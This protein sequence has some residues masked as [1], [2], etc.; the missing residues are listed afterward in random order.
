[1][2]LIKSR[3][4][5]TFWAA[6][7]L[8]L[9][10][11][12]AYYGVFNLLA[13]YLTGSQ[14]TGALGFSQVE[15]G[16]IMGIV[17]AI[18]Y[19]LPVI[20]GSLADRFGYKRVLVTAFIVLSSGYYLMGLVS[21][22]AG[23]FLT[24]FYV[25]IGA[26]M[27]KPII[28]ATIARTTNESNSSVGFGIFYMIINIGGLIGPLVASELREI[29][30]NYIFVMSG[31]A[32]LVNLVIVLFFYRE[33]GRAADPEQAAVPGQ[34]P[35]S[36]SIRNA[37]RNI[38][39]A[40]KDTKFML[41][42]LIIIAGWTVYW[43]YFFSL[44]IYI[45]QWVDTGVVY[46]GI[47]TIFPRLADALATQD[48]VILAEKFITLDALFIVSFQVLLSSLVMRFKPINTMIAGF[49]VNAIGITLAL[50]TRNGWFLVLSILVFSAGEMAFSPKIL[51]YIGRLAPGDRAALYMGTYFMPIAAGNI[52]AGLLSGKIYE[53]TADKFIMLAKEVSKWG[54]QIP[55]ISETFSQNDYLAAAAHGMGMDVSQ[56]N[57]YLWINYNPALFGL[58]LM[59]IGVLTCLLLIVY[60]KFIFRYK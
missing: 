29:S 25:A 33:P 37:F 45:D 11:R 9:F 17:N 18:L 21:S 31:G 19:F 14:E 40:L 58:I 30:W 52:F 12:W 16:L 42:L 32:I 60:D 43:Q 47:H 54:L 36:E 8:E 39:L 38:Y 26:A 59:G 53:I 3:F 24:F 55:P 7:S 20:T 28:S 48:G 46:R 23:V 41:F 56:L 35:F 27:F 5:R 15:K 2:S 51:E 6:N 4:P 22:F 1:M 49:L 34:E 10:E 50:L 57:Q 13:L 44:P